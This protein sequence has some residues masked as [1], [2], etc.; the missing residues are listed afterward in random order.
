MAYKEPVVYELETDI[1]GEPVTVFFT[2]DEG[3]PGCYSGLPE[4]CW[5]SEPESVEFEKV[6]Y[7]GVDILLMVLLMVESQV[8]ELSEKCIN[9]V[10]EEKGA[11]ENAAAE[12][13][14][15]ARREAMLDI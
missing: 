13:E 5:P 4:N 6:M 2:Y 3:D 9:Y 15:E 14:F 12:A 10:N 11:A 7:K 1:D 8:K